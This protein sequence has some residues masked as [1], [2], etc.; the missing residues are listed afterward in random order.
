MR[1][2]SLAQASDAEQLL[3]LIGSHRSQRLAVVVRIH[4]TPASVPG[5][6]ELVVTAEREGWKLVVI[7]GVGTSVDLMPRTADVTAV[8]A[9]ALTEYFMAGGVANVANGIRFAAATLLGSKAPYDPLRLMP[10]HGLYHPD[11]LVTDAEE[12][13]AH[14][15]QDIPSVWVLFYRAHVL[16][17]N[18]EF[19]DS[20]IRALERRGLAAIGVFT[21]SLR[22]RD[23]AGMPL[24]LRVLPQ[25]QSPDII[26]NT[27]AFPVFTLSSVDP[28]C[29]DLK[30]TPFDTIGAPLLQAICCGIGRH[31]V[32][33]V[34]SSRVG[35]RGGGR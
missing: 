20:L 10:A 16:S 27:V 23:S 28:T 18:L 6:T 19:V 9:G 26:V 34:R 31:G 3:S 12:W 5:L 30:S 8:F 15:T 29:G 2:H 17:G 7:S 1:G 14:R 35:S 32:V 25:Q 13:S 22:E 11:L 24:A 33:R 4:G 21:S